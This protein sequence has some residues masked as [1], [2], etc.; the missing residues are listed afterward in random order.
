MIDLTA[1]YTLKLGQKKNHL[2]SAYAGTGFLIRHAFLSNGVDSDD[3]NR[4]TGSTAGDDVS[5]IN[6]SFFKNMNF[7]YPEIALSYS[8]VLSPLWKAGLETRVYLPAG[9]FSEGRGVDNMIFS[10]AVKISYK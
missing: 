2:I 3:T 8:Y 9:S 1:G 7:F 5:D 10:F 4:I 6:D